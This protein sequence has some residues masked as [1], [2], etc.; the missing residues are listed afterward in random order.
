MTL[1]DLVRF[2]QLDRLYYNTSKLK[3]LGFK[4]KSIHKMFDDCI[5]SLIKQGHLPSFALPAD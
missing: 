3:S 4:F 1:I 5:A 2:E